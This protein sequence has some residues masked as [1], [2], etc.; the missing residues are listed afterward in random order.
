[1][2]RRL[3]VNGQPFLFDIEE[4]E[5]SKSLRRSISQFGGDTCWQHEIRNRN[6]E[7]DLELYGLS[8]EY[9]DNLSVKDFF[10]TPVENETERYKIIEFIKTYEWLGNISQYPTHWFAAYHKNILS[11]A[12][13]MNLPNSFSKLLGDET[14]KLER[15]ISRGA[16]ISWS[17]KNLPSHM[18]MWSIRWMAK[19]TQYRLFTAYADPSANETGTIYQACNFYYL[20]DDFGSTRKYKNPYTKKWVSDRFF[21]QRT[22]YKKYAQELN[23]P[24]NPS[25]DGDTG[26]CWENIPKDIEEKLRDMSKEKQSKADCIEMPSKRKYAY[27]LGKD[28]R[29]T[30]EL[31]KKFESLNQTYDYPNE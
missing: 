12:L 14:D 4:V 10:V 27:V 2:P 5:L 17:P 26:I 15:L 13:I 8:R 1:M 31:R 24:W 25:W 11:G 16:C 3:V 6:L 9:V 18:I 7:R 29:E 30:K 21:R 22:A 20:G 28:K 19:N 23:I